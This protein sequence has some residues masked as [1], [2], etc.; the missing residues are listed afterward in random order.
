MKPVLIGK[1]LKKYFGNV[2]AVDGV[3]IQ[4]NPGEVVGLIGPN[5]AGKTTL[6]NLLSG[7]LK[8][9]S[10][11]VLV[12]VGG[13]KEYINVAGWNP[14]KITG[15]GVARAFQIPNIFENMTVIDNLRAAIIASKKLYGKTLRFY[16]RI[17]DVER[18]AE[19]LLKLFGLIEKAE[20]IAGGLGHGERKILDIALALTVKPK[21]LMLDEPTAGLSAAEKPLI[22]DLIRKLK[23]EINAAILVVEHDLDVVF[24]VSERVVVMHEGK[25]LAEGTPEEIKSDIRVR[26][27]YFGEVL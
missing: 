23:N 7:V 24:T 14:A 25:I 27:A 4:I 13:K 18:E 1:G 22:I 6:L 19:K 21:I 3:F 16:D 26:E 8:P 15:L 2:R 9:D 12:Y 10:G 20:S 11:E 17:N 5:G